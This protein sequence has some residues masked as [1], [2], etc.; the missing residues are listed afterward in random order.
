[1]SDVLASASGLK[2]RRAFIY[3]MLSLMTACWITGLLWSLLGDAGPPKLVTIVVLT[4]LTLI[5]LL[6]N[7]W[8]REL[9]L[10]TKLR[11]GILAGVL[12]F[13]SLLVVSSGF[14]N[15]SGLLSGE[16][17]NR[18]L[19][20]D[21][22]PDIALNQVTSFFLVV[23]CWWLGL[24]LGDMRLT[25][26]NLFRYFYVC[27]IILVT[28][29]VF[30]VSDISQGLSW[31]YFMFLFVSLVTM[32]L[33]RIEEAARRSQHQG[34]PFT[35]YWLTQTSS[36]AGIVMVI[37]GVAQAL[38]LAY[39]LGLIM[40]LIG[41]L[42][43]FLA[44]PL[45]LLG[46]QI[47]SSFGLEAT[48][49]G[50]EA[51]EPGGAAQGGSVVTE[52]YGP[53]STQHLCAGIVFLVFFVAVVLAI[54]YAARR[55]RQIVRDYEKEEHVAMPSLGERIAEALEERVERLSINL[56]GVRRLRRR[57]A[58][59]SIRRIYAALTA[60]AAQRGYPRPVARTPYEHIAALRRA[61]PG[62]GAQVRQITEAYVA[63]HYGQVPETREALGEIK[64][65]W[66]HVREA[67][68]HTVP[69]PSGGTSPEVVGGR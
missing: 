68:R 6:L 55:W 24:T 39:G 14:Y 30:F 29:S 22:S 40:A 63:A 57:L 59:R 28:P 3:L 20:D 16:W 64:A 47:D 67:A 31:L 25:S 44:Y 7:R 8:L 56:P 35:L 49:P 53:T 23:S 41:P 38:K 10:T 5:P 69:T 45:V 61:F 51:L 34:S 42:F 27:I 43:T 18:S 36:F 19:S 21:L 17:M 1:M 62:C 13:L 58:T 32:G 54:V 50:M 52:T 9:A 15:D 4:P 48:P 2:N 33:G 26:V 37:V 65:T 46:N 66:E 11:R 60:L 12:I